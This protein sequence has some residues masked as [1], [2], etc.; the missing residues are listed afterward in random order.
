MG[1][2]P[3]AAEGVRR[4]QGVEGIPG[5]TNAARHAYEPGEVVVGIETDRACSRPR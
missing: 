1:T 2:C 4:P 5:S 3:P